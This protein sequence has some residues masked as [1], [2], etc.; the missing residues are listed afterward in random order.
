MAAI[1]SPEELLEKLPMEGIDKKNG[2]VL[3]SGTLATKGGLVFGDFYDL[4]MADPVL[5]RSIKY[6]YK[7]KILPQFI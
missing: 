4:E 2:L 3:F 1:L 6:S 5:N 7:V